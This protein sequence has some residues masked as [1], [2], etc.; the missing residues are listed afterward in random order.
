MKKFAKILLYAMPAVLFF[1]YYPVIK[2][3]ASDS[4]NFELSLPIIWI[5]LFAF[6]SLTLIPQFITRAKSDK[7]PIKKWQI[8]LL[9]LF[10]LYVATSLLWTP[11]F[12]RGVLTAGVFLCIILSIVSILNLSITKK[13]KHA[14]LK[15]FF[16]S[17][18]LV[19]LFC[20]LQSIL[21]V[22]GVPTT[23]TLACRG[24]TTNTFGFPHPNGFAI[25]PQFMGNLLIAPTLLAIYFTLHGEFFRKSTYHRGRF[26]GLAIFLC[27]TLF[28]TFSRGAIYAFCVA[29]AMIFVVELIQKNRRVVLL[30][31]V[32]VGSLAACLVAQGAFAA[33]SPT[34][35]D[36]WSGFTK[37]I[38]QLTLGRIDLR[39]TAKEFSSSPATSEPAVDAPIID[40]VENTTNTTG[41]TAPTSSAFD[42][43]VAESTNT[44]LNLNAI[45]AQTWSSSPESL[46]FGVGIGGAGVAMYDAGLIDSPK[47]ITQNEYTEILL[48]FGIV[49]VVFL[50][51]SVVILL[52]IL[53][54]HFI[55]KYPEA[56]YLAA[57]VLAYLL[58]MIFFSGLPNVLHIYLLPPLALRFF[59]NKDL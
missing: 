40:V 45:S 57:L 27:T 52:L 24:C 54:R 7:Q 8:A 59:Q 51:I 48:E 46:V 58:S 49:G 14:L 38:H 12:S 4:M 17:S 21:D 35:D 56:I 13:T 3:G 26:L 30:I 55:F 16:I 6:A 22:T 20:W 10:P 39:P 53:Y 23:H 33:I 5:A 43:Y 31:S 28:F 42:G 37:S 11:N 2:I 41:Q 18:V 29:C 47:E 15:I 34:N 50:A 9:S 25:E 32:L 1:S 36:F 19:A 44:R